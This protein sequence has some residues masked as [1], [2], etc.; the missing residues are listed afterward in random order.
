MLTIMLYSDGDIWLMVPGWEFD[1]DL[2][3]I[4]CTNNTNL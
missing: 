1:V 3:V 2:C 4:K